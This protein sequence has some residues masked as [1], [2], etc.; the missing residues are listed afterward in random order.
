METGTG[1]RY[2]VDHGHTNLCDSISIGTAA[3]INPSGVIAFFLGRT[4]D[5]FNQFL[6]GVRA[7]H[8]RRLRNACGFNRD[9][10]APVLLSQRFNA[11]VNFAAV[12][13][14]PATGV[15][16]KDALFGNRVADGTA[17]DDADRHARTLAFEILKVGDGDGEVSGSQNR[18]A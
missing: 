17:F 11:L 2:A 14:V 4:V 10:V 18:A 1:R 12:F 6:R 8:S 9:A 16:L 7:G 3:G 5:N 13:V 15:D